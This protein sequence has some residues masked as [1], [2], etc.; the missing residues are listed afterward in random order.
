MYTKER[1][2]TEEILRQNSS[3]MHSKLFTFLELPSLIFGLDCGLPCNLFWDGHGEWSSDGKQ[4][5]PY[6]PMD[7]DGMLTDFVLRHSCLF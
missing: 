5:R 2:K 4:W 1:N 3:I 6:I 7:L